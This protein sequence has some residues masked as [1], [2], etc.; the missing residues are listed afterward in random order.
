MKNSDK[1]SLRYDCDFKKQK[2]PMKMA[3]KLREFVKSDYKTNTEK[4][5]TALLAI[6]RYRNM[7]YRN[8]K[9]HLH[10]IENI[11]YIGITLTKTH[12]IFL[13]LYNLG[14]TFFFF[15]FNL[16]ALLVGF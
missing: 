14:E 6:N 12:A 13:T 11:K 1:M 4:F 7:K 8:M 10:S 3:L 9:K 2:I 16:T 15:F 5:I